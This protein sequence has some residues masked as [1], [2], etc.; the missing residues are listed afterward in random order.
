M[1]RIPIEKSRPD[2]RLEFVRPPSQWPL[3]VYFMAFVGVMKFFY[4][5]ITSN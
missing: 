5:L 4:F 1:L 3:I 2:E